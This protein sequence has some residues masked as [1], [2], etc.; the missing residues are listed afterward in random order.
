MK[1]KQRP[2][3][4]CLSAQWFAS[5]G[6]SVEIITYHNYPAFCQPL[7]GFVNVFAFSKPPRGKLTN[8]R[9]FCWLQHILAV[10]SQ[11]KQYTHQT[12]ISLFLKAKCS[13]LI[14]WWISKSRRKGKA[15]IA[16][17]SKGHHCTSPQRADKLGCCIILADSLFLANITQTHSPQD[18]LLK[19]RYIIFCSD[20]NSQAFGKLQRHAE[21]EKNVIFYL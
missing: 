16:M 19:T 6:H 5:C 20:P 12:L 2:H 1:Q 10:V 3:A 9:E 15:A 21:L 14:N 8:Q 7:Q 17:I 4:L 11:Q 18:T 13:L